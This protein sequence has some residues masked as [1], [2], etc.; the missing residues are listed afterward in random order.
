M[1]H[2]C[3]FLYCTSVSFT[4][5]LRKSEPETLK[6]REGEWH[7]LREG[8]VTRSSF[9]TDPLNMHIYSQNHPLAQICH[10]TVF[11]VQWLHFFNKSPNCKAHQLNHLSLDFPL[12]DSKRDHKLI[13]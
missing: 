7:W 11:D 1:Q 4:R 2:T 6:E 5:D 10:F 12:E 13:S 8:W 3:K 9:K